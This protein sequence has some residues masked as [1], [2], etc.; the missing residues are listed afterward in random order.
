M[1]AARLVLWDIDGTLLSS[2]PVARRAFEAGLTAVFGTTGDIDGYRFEGKLDPMIVEEL[3]LGAGVPA[4]VVS[5]RGRDALDHYLESLERALEDAPPALK[6]GI[7]PLL[8]ATSGQPGVVNALLTG[9]VER[10]AR[11]KLTSAGL[12]DLFAFGVWGD[13]AAR[14]VELGPVALR[15]AAERT[16]RVFSPG[17]CVVVGDSRHDVETGLALGARVVA[18][19]TGWTK[20]EELEAAGAHEVFA[21]FSDLDRSLEAILG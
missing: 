11:I 19:A 4:E 15:R 7:A 8:A 6:P 20:R 12:W 18:V 5:A 2:G 14:R 13:E 1:S 10:G 21:D 17:E 16:G 9:N 3:M